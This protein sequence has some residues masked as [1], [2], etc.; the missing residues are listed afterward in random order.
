V[1]RGQRRDVGGHARR[2]RFREGGDHHVGARQGDLAVGREAVVGDTLVPFAR[3]REGNA[4]RRHGA[5]A[6][7]RGG[8]DGLAGR[9]A[10]VAPLRAGA[11]VARAL[12]HDRDVG[13]GGV[14]GGQE[15]RVDRDRL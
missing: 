4:Q 11:E 2:L 9:H 6:K 15:S 8:V 13:A 14:P 7:G 10:R 1:A 12:R 5:A 3:V